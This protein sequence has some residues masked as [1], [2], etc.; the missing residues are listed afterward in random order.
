MASNLRKH[1]KLFGLLIDENDARFAKFGDFYF[2]RSCTSA[3][4]DTRWTSTFNDRTLI[5]VTACFESSVLFAAREA[6]CSDFMFQALF[7]LF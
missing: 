3:D 4:Y 5:N 7:S 6:W 1:D 2:P